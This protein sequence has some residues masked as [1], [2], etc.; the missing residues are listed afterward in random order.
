MERLCLGCGQP[1]PK[2]ADKQKQYHKECLR[3]R[4]KEKSKWMYEDK[5]RQLKLLEHKKRV[6]NKDDF[7]ARV[8]LAEKV[9]CTSYGKLEHEAKKQG[10]DLE[11]Y[12]DGLGV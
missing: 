1:L 2:N 10:L 5:K 8:A 4:T 12:L 9:L 11:Q 3:K 7:W 6:R